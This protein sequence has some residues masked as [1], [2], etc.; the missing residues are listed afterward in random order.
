MSVA[1]SM[2]SAF[3]KNINVEK[4][5][6][7]PQIKELMTLLQGIAADFKS[8]KAQNSEII[9]RLD[10]LEKS[11]EEFGSRLIASENLI[12]HWN[13][14]FNNAKHTNSNASRKCAKP[15]ATA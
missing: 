7:A 15:N 6:E 9:S 8:I 11:S 1:E 13:E 5:L 3:V 14:G 12:E 2:I 4:L 10:N